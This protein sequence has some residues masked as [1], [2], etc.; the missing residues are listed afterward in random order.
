MSGGSGKTASTTDTAIGNLKVQTSIAGT[1][2]PLC[3]G[4]PRVPANLLWYGAFTAIPHA[5]ANASTGAGKG[6]GGQKPTNTTFTYTAAVMM[7][8]CEGAVKGVTEAW[9]D[10]LVYGATVINAT[11]NQVSETITVPASNGLY[12]VALASVYV[13][14]VSCTAGQTFHYG[15]DYTCDAHGNYAFNNSLWG[16]PVLITYIVSNT[17]A[18]PNALAGLGLSLAGGWDAQGTWGYLATNFPSQALGYSGIA[19]LYAPAYDLGTDANVGNHNFELS[20]FTEFSATIHD[21]V[22]AVILA[23]FLTNGRYGAQWPRTA[24]GDLT[25]YSNYTTA[26]GIFMSPALTTQQDAATWV[27]Y[28]LSLS[29]SDCVWSEGKIKVVPL[30]DQ[31][32]SANGATYTPNTTPVYDIGED[33]YIASSG[34]APLTPH[35]KSSTD[36]FNHVQLE[37]LD[38]TNAY[39]TQIADWK[40][41][42]D[43]STR[44]LLTQDTTEGHAICDPGVAQLVASLIGQRQIAVARTFSFTLPWTFSLLEPLDLVTLT[45]SMLSMLRV[46]VRI[47]S[48]T[49]NDDYTFDIE[50]ED[51][52]IGFAS[53]PTYGVQQSIGFTHDY[54]AHPGSVTTPFFFEPPIEL[55]TTGL[56]V[57]VA[58][59][60][61]SA[62]WGGCVI[63]TSLDNVHYDQAGRIDGGVRYGALTAAASA[64][65]GQTLSVTLAGLG[66]PILSASAAAAA[67]DQ[68]LVFV[69]DATGGE[70][71]DYQTATLTAAN[72]YNLATLLRGRFGTTPVAHTA[73]QTVVRVDDAIGKSDPLPLSMIGQ[74]IFV[75]LCSFNVYGGGMQALADV[76]P[77]TYTITGAM[78]KLPPS[79]VASVSITFQNYSVLVQWPPIPDQDLLDY[80]VRTGGSSWETATVLTHAGGTSYLWTAQQTTSGLNVWV[81]ARD[82]FGNYSTTAASAL[83]VVPAPAATNLL[84]T[85]AGPNIVLSWS[86]TT[87]AYAIDHYLITSGPSPT[88]QSPLASSLTTNFTLRVAFAGTAC[89]G[90]AAVDAAGNVGPFVYS[91]VTINAPAAVIPGNGAHPSQEVIDNN[92]LLYWTAP[93]ASLPIDH[94]DVRKG[95][96]YAA[97]GSI[98][99]NGN[100]TFTTTFEQQSGTYTYWIVAY[101]SAGNAGPPTAI[102][103]TVNQ[104]PDY[105]LRSSIDTTFTTAG[106]ET[107]T[108]VGMYTENGR[109][110]GPTLNQTYDAHFTSQSW[111]TPNDQINAGDPLYF[112]PSATSGYYEDVIDYG[113]ILAG[114]TITVTQ[115]ANQL[116]GAVAA[117]VTISYKTNSGDAWTAA[118]TGVT[119]VFATNFRFVRVHIDYVATGNG[120]LIEVTDLNIKLAVKLRSDSGSGTANAS[121]SS[122]TTVSFNVAFI[123]A[124][125]PV[126]QPTGASALIGMCDF[127]GATPYP[128][129]FNVYLFDRNGNRVSGAF[130]W[131]ARGY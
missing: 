59:S 90:V 76:S 73:G 58:A 105:I 40:D 85:L 60:G 72:A 21:A 110:Y 53:P 61:S 117:T 65:A 48:I 94:Y 26:T 18:T 67:A 75:K 56:E 106:V 39:N 8:L 62:S 22:P 122:G 70:F 79:N 51:C 12:T 25:A 115:T 19:Y 93:A 28:L 66:G 57:W 15:S 127:N 46:P 34:S 43:I 97:G 30:G 52:P 99:S 68:S 3:W 74:T 69:G 31:A 125:T 2:I 114:T 102:T 37:F 27:T 124:Q 112:Q 113:A 32:A 92:V 130:A 10:K 6:G 24:L 80:E 16:T 82:T 95:A 83:L 131:Q 103:A 33:H 107:A 5:T 64:G 129:T 123:Q 111:S 63:Y 108:L 104:P 1:C 47:N 38:R 98:G 23:D 9:R 41:D 119:S 96:S 7:G 29:N 49:E 86:A 55:T 81:K 91:Q 42:A 88:S 89:F 101:D 17:T 116:A 77:F 128:T 44:G 20:T 54:N 78:V 121:D 35:N 120:N 109:L 118:G 14:N 87:G 36:T 100:A 11:T 126:I 45:E 71:I 4:R 13:A 50:A 84:S